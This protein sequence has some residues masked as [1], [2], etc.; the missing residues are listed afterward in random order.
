MDIGFDGAVNRAEDRFDH[1]QQARQIREELAASWETKQRWNLIRR[2][3]EM[4]TPDIM[5]GIRI[6]PYE[7]GLGEKMTPIEYALW[8]EI[9]Y[10]GLPFYLQYPVGRRF[11]DFGDP[12]FRI[13][14]EADGAAY[15]TPAGDA[16]KDSELRSFGWRVFRVK[17]KDAL[18]RDNALDFLMGYYPHIPGARHRE[19]ED[20]G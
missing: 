12:V 19:S 1:F 20:E 7:I 15:H 16:Q 13:A 18:W 5:D 2:Y 14:I 17:G 9:R 3:Y 8:C 6:S 10:V 11:V 4:V